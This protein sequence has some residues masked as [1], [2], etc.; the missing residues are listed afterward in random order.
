MPKPKLPLRALSLLVLAALA[1]ASVGLS[2]MVRSI[3]ADQQ[4]RLLSE[5]SAEASL[6]LGTLFNG[7]ES[8]LPTL[9]ASANPAVGAPS[10]F[11]ATAK[12]LLGLA[13]TIGVLHDT[14]GAFSV[15]EAVGSGPEPGTPVGADRAALAIRAL[16][17][18]GAVTGL[19][20]TPQGR[21]LSLAFGDGNGLVLYEDL[22]FDPAKRVNEG[23]KGPFSE[24]DGALYAS[25]RPDP[26]ALVLSTTSHL[27]LSGHVAQQTVTV[28]LDNFLLVSKAKRPLVGSFA[29]N[30]PWGV[31]F[32]GL[33]A[34]LLTAL[35]VETLSRRRAYAMALVEERTLE[36]RAALDERARLEGDERKAREIAE[37]A[38][39]SKSEFLSRMSHELRTPLNAV[40]G[41]GQLLQL[42][43]L[44]QSQEEA[45]EQIVRGGRHLLDL[46][47]D[48][49][50]ISRIET[51]TLPLSPEPVS[52]AE[53]IDDTLTLIRPLAAHRR[54]HLTVEGA[55]ESGVYVLADRQ[56]LKQVLLNLVSNA[57]KYN[58]DGG[59]VTVS[60]ELVDSERARLL[61]ADT[62]PG[63]PAELLERLFVP[64]DRLG[65]ERGEVEGT[66][67]G[68]A[69]S[70]H[71]AEAMGGVL[72]VQSTYGEGSRFW[73]E[74]SVV[75]DPVQQYDRLVG[76]AETDL[77]ARPRGSGPRRQV[78]YIEDNLANLRLVERLLQRRADIELLPAMQGRLG[79]ALAR[80]HR[81]DLI[82]LDLHLP[83]IGGDA[84]LRELRAHRR[85]ADIPVVIVSAD[86]TPGQI[87]RLTAEGAN[88]YLTKPFDVQSLLALINDLIEIDSPAR[89]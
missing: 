13:T 83:D 52:V 28:G 77:D 24:L 41:F 88:A 69:L 85:T 63:I 81:P 31:L 27:P 11:A 67:V 25:S 39:R 48:V 79:L 65:A 62:G 72:E 53:V 4:R 75:E 61:V 89:P 51:G 21:R 84:V 58:R 82:L 38:N 8:T 54:I 20:G 49:L 16:A 86:A 80:E 22:A 47:N 50:D 34:T 70:R 30:A 43:E 17:V 2:V 18:K 87:E 74:L 3:V 46:I 19:V 57:I 32:G 5:S 15:V 1:G 76:P 40:L 35:L 68:L 14:N 23:N 71:L 12:P 44:N 78:L 36:L 45:V 73:V 10:Q 64:F 56:R 7:V 29:A 59:A 60:C 55:S 9:S 33:L 66:G 26:S 42:D 6:V 37:A